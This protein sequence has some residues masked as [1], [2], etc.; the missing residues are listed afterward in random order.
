MVNLRFRQVHLD[1]HTP[2][3]IEGI[4]EKFDP[5]EFK[6]TLRKG[7][8]DSITL[9]SKCHHG[10]S[11]H[12]TKENEMNPHLGFDLLGE[13]LK[14]CK[15]IG[16]NAPVYISAGL[17]EKDAN[18][19]PEWLFRNKDESL[20]WGINFIEKAAFHLL[21][22]NTGYM[23]KLIAQ[24]EEVMVLYNPVGI[25]LDIVGEKL[26]Y[27]SSCRND[28]IK[29]GLNPLDESDVKI[30]TEKVYAEYAAKVE[31]AVRKYNNDTTIFHNS[32]LKSKK[33]KETICRLFLNIGYRLQCQRNMLPWII[34]RHGFIIFLILIF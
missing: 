30:Q 22:F 26:C 18:T 34:L 17:D 33:A 23:D 16:V 15:E 27:C 10:Y 1:F 21:C 4:G 11:Y 25:F 32:D 31:K 7:H 20:S 9:F 28:M 12:P 6:A 5:E 19:H 8:V 29:S 24:I 3:N 14:A 2:G 13:Q